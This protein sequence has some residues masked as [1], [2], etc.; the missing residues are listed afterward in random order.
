MYGVEKIDGLD[1]VYK[2][3]LVNRVIRDECDV[4]KLCV[5]FIFGVMID[6]FVNDIGE[7]VNF[8]IGVVLLFSILEKLFVRIDKGRE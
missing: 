5:C 3:V 4:N 2:E 1:V 7:F 6:F 8:F